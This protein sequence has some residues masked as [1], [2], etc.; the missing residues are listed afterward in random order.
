MKR[1]FSLIC[2]AAIS[3]LILLA[4]VTGGPLKQPQVVFVTGDH[5]Y[6]SEETM[7][8]VAAAGEKHYGMQTIVLKAYRDENTEENIPGVEALE[9]AEV[10]VFFLRWRRLPDAQLEQLRRCVDAG[11]P[12]VAW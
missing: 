1:S 6:S 9:N 12:G 11:R 4:L 8:L 10:A 5:E 3:M 7:P 2:V